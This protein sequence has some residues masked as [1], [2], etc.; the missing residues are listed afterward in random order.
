MTRAYFIRWKRAAECAPSAPRR[1]SKG[2]EIS[3]ARRGTEEA[4]ADA[5]AEVG[6]LE[7]EEEDEEGV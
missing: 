2:T 3:G 4:D 5:E 7:E 1:R 6:S